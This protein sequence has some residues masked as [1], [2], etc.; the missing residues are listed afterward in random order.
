MIIDAK[1][2]SGS[3]NSTTSSHRLSLSTISSSTPSLDEP[4][5]YSP[6]TL[7]QLPG[8]IKPVN[9][10][11][12]TRTGDVSLRDT[13]LL[14][15][16]LSI[17]PALLP[18]SNRADGKRPNLSLETRA[19]VIDADVWIAPGAAAALRGRECPDAESK[20]AFIEAKSKHG[21]V[22]LRLNAHEST[23]TSIHITASSAFST[24]IVYLP[25]TFRGTLHTQG[26]VTLSDSLG[27]ETTV[28]E[29]TDGVQRAWIGEFDDPSDGIAVDPSSLYIAA[30]EGG[31]TLAYVDEQLT[32]NEEVPVGTITDVAVNPREPVFD[33]DI[34]ACPKGLV[35]WITKC[36]E[37][38][39]IQETRIE[40]NVL[41]GSRSRKSRLF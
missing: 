16:A 25:R 21:S 39:V 30:P 27:S 14:D 20:P 22:C 12:V 34:G 3:H 31:I 35:S 29:D 17:P 6:A 7:P 2:D 23:R 5:P 13:F 41:A 36:I 40:M 19:G 9:Y 11:S 38:K 8:R 10:L 24:V 4:P 1:K 18:P 28:L 37:R 32:A 26:E 33:L 15:A